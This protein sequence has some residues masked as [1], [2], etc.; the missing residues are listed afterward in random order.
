MRMVLARGMSRP[1]STMVVATRTSA[2]SRM[3]LSMTRFEFFFA[4]LAV[5]D[6]DAGLGDELLDESGER[7]D[8][9]DAIVDEV[10]LAVAGELVFDGGADELF[11]EGGD[12]GLDGEAV[13]RGSFDERHVAQADERHVEGARNRSGGERE[14]IYIF[15]HFLEALFVGDAEALLL[16]N[17]EQAEVGE[18][19]VFGEEAMR[20]DDDVYFAGFERGHRFLLLSGERKRLIISIRAGKAAKRRLK[21][22]KCWKARTVVGARTATCLLSAMALKAARMATSVLP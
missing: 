6:D 19:Y 10:D 15:A 13:S 3:N 1:F 12:D 2:S 20:A 7:V 8:G 22:S 14:R 21:V 5:A 17:D 16:V 11:V 9:L 4:H 18:F